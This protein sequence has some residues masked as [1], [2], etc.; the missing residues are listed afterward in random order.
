MFFESVVYRAQG[1]SVSCAR[2]ICIE[3]QPEPLFCK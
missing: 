3:N 1:I 2:F